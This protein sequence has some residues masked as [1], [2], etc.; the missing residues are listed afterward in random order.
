MVFLKLFHWLL[1]RALDTSVHRKYV[2]LRPLMVG[3]WMVAIVLAGQPNA[4]AQTRDETPAVRVNL[5]ELPSSRAAQAALR[6]PTRIFWDQTPLRSGL[7]EIS[8]QFRITIWLDR[9]IDPNQLITSTA[10]D[11]Q[12]D[13]SLL[14]KLE[15][16]ASLADAELGLIENVV[17]IGPRRRVSR[18][19]RAAVELYDKLS[20]VGNGPQTA[21]MRELQ[22]EELTTSMGML[23]R[24]ESIW[25][26]EIAGE[27]PHD[28]FHAGQFL[29][30]ATL[31]TQA[32]VVLGGF[33]RELE[34]M[35]G[36]RFRIAPLEQTDRWQANYSKADLN[37]SSLASLRA[38]YMGARCQTRG[39][40]IHVQGPTGFHLALL[41]PPQVDRPGLAL[42]NKSERYQFEVSGTP[43]A[44]VLEHLGTSL[45]FELQWD[46]HFPDA[47]R[48]RRISF[49]VSQ[50]T[51]D[52]LLD[53]IARASELSITRQ[54]TKVNVSSPPK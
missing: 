33:E 12:G 45:G 43:V 39:N 5:L 40:V 32:T 16:I 7:Q 8:Q 26:I 27:L 36:N 49:K 41:A 21:T 19:Q 6:A 20:P 10:A 25:T 42:G 52:Q 2:M 29:Q 17:Y 9:D 37:L 4:W 13:A 48:E 34:W 11:T 24:V 22:W 31:A 18:L 47:V 14:K 23:Q 46:E 44:S 3:R 50:A 30:P 51:L 15:H 54:G 38:E 28:L 53:E 35:Q 1:W